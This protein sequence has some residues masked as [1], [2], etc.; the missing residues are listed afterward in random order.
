MKVKR[1]EKNRLSKLF[2]A[3][4]A[5]FFSAFRTCLRSRYEEANEQYFQNPQRSPTKTHGEQRKFENTAQA[6]VIGRDRRQFLKK[7]LP[8]FYINQF[9]KTNQLTQKYYDRSRQ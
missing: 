1:S 2:G 9:S 7:A 3:I 4:S 6:S 5:A 8:N